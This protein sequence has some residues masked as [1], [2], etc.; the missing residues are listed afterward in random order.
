[1]KYLLPII[2]LPLLVSAAD[3]PEKT[4]AFPGAEGFGRYTTGGR[5]GNV[6]HVTSL[7]DDARLKRHPA[8]GARS[9]GPADHSIRRVGPL[10]IFHPD[11][12]FHQIQP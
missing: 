10:Y 3:T 12:P 5:G 9:V 1:M 2:A 8:L 6:Y 7:K 4:P 11:S